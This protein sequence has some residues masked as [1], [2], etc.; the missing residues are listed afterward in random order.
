MP[1]PQA[2]AFGPL[3]AVRRRSTQGPGRREPLV[4]EAVGVLDGESVTC[5]PTCSPGMGRR[6]E[7][8]PVVAD[9]LVVTGQGPG[10]AMLFALAVLAQ[11]EGPKRAHSV[12][13]GLLTEFG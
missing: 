1:P 10:S 11:L 2:A 3:L 9:G 4:L 13:N 7:N 8:V 12:A 5:Y 6:V